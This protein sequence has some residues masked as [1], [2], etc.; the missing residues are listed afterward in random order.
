MLRL[1]L[2]RGLVGSQ[3]GKAY[4]EK[5]RPTSTFA[6]EFTSKWRFPIKRLYRYQPQTKFAFLQIILSS[7][8]TLQ[9]PL[10]TFWVS[11]PHSSTSISVLFLPDCSI[12]SYYHK[13]LVKVH[14]YVEYSS[15]QTRQNILSYSN[16]LASNVLDF[17]PRLWAFFI[18]WCT[19]HSIWAFESHLRV[20]CRNFQAI[21]VSSKQKF[22]TVSKII[23]RKSG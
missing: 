19:K 11:I 23:G 2:N 20:T 6:P 13:G 15:F 22:L 18:H 8:F 1:L 7:N 21:W 3:G 17:L 16:I 14:N 4:H 5:I 9:A 10:Y 12:S